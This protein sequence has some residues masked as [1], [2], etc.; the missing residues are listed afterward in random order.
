MNRLLARIFSER[1]KAER[2]D[3]EAIEMAVRSALDQAGAAALSEL[4][5]FEPPPADQRSV[6]GPCGQQ[7]PYHELRSKSHS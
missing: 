6:P 2:L 3:W 1:R 7:A 4:L 5:Q